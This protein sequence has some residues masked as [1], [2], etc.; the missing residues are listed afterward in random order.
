MKR[1]G[2]F[3]LV[4]TI[5]VLLIIGALIAAAVPNLGLMAERA[6][7]IGVRGVM[8]SL[9]TAMQAY[10]ADNNGV[11]P[12]IGCFTQAARGAPAVDI[13]YW[14]PGGDPVGVNGKPVR[15]RLP[16]NPYTDR[17]YNA[18]GE[19]MDGESYFGYLSGPG[20]NA[21]CLST[22]PGCRYANL[23]APAGLQGTVC[24]VSYVSATNADAVAE[25]GIV[26]YGRDVTQPMFDIVDK[27][28]AGKQ[29]V[30]YYVLTN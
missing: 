17:A 23:T 8:R 21:R 16:V 2:G 9:N 27:G 3:T 24:V 18:E 11:F 4:E 30:R 5:V 28:A 14:F 1:S 25:Y 6:R 19:D 26:G 20:Q 29:D 7:R 12:G 10:A 15:G 13:T 22:D